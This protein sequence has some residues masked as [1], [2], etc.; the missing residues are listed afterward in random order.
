MSAGPEKTDDFITPRQSRRNLEGVGFKRVR[1]LPGSTF[2]DS[3][4]LIVVPTR[5][6]ETDKT[7]SPAWDMTMQNVARP[8]N[9]KVAGPVYVCGDEVGEAYNRAISQLALPSKFKFVLTVED[10]N[11]LPPDAILRLRES[12]DLGPFDAVSGLYFTKGELNM[13]MAYGDPERFR[14][15][16]ELEFEPR[17]VRACLEAGE[18]MEVNGIA[19]GCALWRTDLFRRVAAPWYVTVQEGDKGGGTQDLTF[20]ARAR[21]L[22]ARFAVD[23]RVRVGHLNT[24]DGVVY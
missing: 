9:Q 2:K 7:I 10:D 8:M 15:T 5:G 20:C 17:D 21:R 19:M 18:V 4:M 14:T 6:R 1:T 24:D 22:G 3:S 16:G 11:L 12:I 13:P 23:M